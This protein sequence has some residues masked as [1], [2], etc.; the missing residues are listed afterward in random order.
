VYVEGHYTRVD[1]QL[2]FERCVN[3]SPCTDKIDA[4]AAE[5]FSPGRLTI[6]GN[7]IDAGDPAFF[8]ANQFYFN[9]IGPDGKSIVP[10]VIGAPDLGAYESCQPATHYGPRATCRRSHVNAVF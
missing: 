9:D 10:Y 7:A 4:Y 2:I 6:T 8:Q 3:S 1:K 5:E